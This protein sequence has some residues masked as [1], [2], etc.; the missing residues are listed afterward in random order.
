[1]RW[2]Q[3]AKVFALVAATAAA[4][5]GFAGIGAATTVP[6]PAETQTVLDAGIE[7]FDA[8][9]T[10][11]ELESPG[12]AADPLSIVALEPGQPVD[13][14]PQSCLADLIAELTPTGGLADEVASLSTTNYSVTETEDVSSD[15]Y[16]VKGG[17]AVVDVAQSDRLERVT[18][19][20]AD[21]AAGECL[22]A[23]AVELAET[24]GIDFELSVIQSDDLGV[25]DSSASLTFAGTEEGG[26][27]TTAMIAIA[28]RGDALALVTIDQ[29]SDVGVEVDPAAALEALLSGVA[30]A[31]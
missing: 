2:M 7:A 8:Y 23:A 13:Q 30:P 10:G 1:M 4:S 21:P 20:L 28:E 3:R 17:V 18:A 5:A 6:V 31:G 15:G 26:T 24:E 14:P 16:L 25:G 9:L 29:T 19:A 11:L 27:E 22:E 12:A